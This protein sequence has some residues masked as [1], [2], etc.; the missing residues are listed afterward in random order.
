MFYRLRGI[1]YL[2]LCLFLLPVS[3]KAQTGAN[4]S[5]SDPNTDAFPII[6]AYLDVRDAQG[7]F[8]RHL[9]AEQV[10]V[11][12]NGVPLP[13][14]E[15]RQLRPGVQVVVALNPGPSFGIRNSKAISRYDY[16]KESLAN[17]AK[18]RQCSTLDDWS[19]LITGGPSISH[20]S[21]PM[22]WL[23]TLETEQVD[24][25]SAIP[26]LDILFLID[27][28]PFQQHSSLEHSVA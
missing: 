7:I 19:L 3:A 17:W 14:T 25:R 1:S 8:V 9:S 6:E 18:S 26:N 11:L 21:D 15:I 13:I 2:I 5:L 4:A 23:A 20:V 24:A 10:R 28:Q 27:L 22:Q 16:I 12:E